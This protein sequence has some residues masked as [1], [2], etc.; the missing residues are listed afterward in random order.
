MPRQHESVET[1]RE[2]RVAPQPSGLRV[3]YLVE[4]SSADEAR[5]IEKL[6]SE[7]E[8]YVQVRQLS[9]GKLM[10]YVVQALESDASLLD[11]IED[12]L[13]KTC[14]FLVTQR[15]FDE[16]IYRIVKDLCEET[17]SKLLPVLR[18]NICGKIEP[19]PN[20]LVS[21][22]DEDGSVMMSRCYCA[23]CTAESSAPSNK[24]YVRSLL[25][26]DKRNFGTLEH[27]ELVRRPLK[28][29]PIRFKIA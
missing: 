6:F 19:F 11:A 27:A 18:C 8:I 2:I 26:A 7:L 21:L 9:S 4:T 17:S 3:V 10:S 14:G 13:K 16:L 20:T 25:S 1:I 12:V 23:S 29:Q 15:S 22:S 28:E 5:D 24:E